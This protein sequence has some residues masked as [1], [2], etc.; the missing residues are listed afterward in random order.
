MNIMMWVG[1]SGMFANQRKLD[2][3]ANNLANVN[4][5]GFKA[6]RALFSDLLYNPSPANPNVQYGAGA[7]VGAAIRDATQGPIQE[8]NGEYDLAIYGPGYFRLAS[9]EGERVYS[10]AGTFQRDARG[11]L[12]DGNG[13]RLLLANNRPLQIP[14][15]AVSFHVAEDGEVTVEE[16]NRRGE[17][18]TRRLGRIG[19][20]QFDNVYGLEAIGGNMYR[21]T[22]ASGSARIRND[23]SLLR[24]GALEAANVDIATQMMDLILAQRAY[25]LSARAVQTAEQMMTMA[26]NLRG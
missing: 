1:A 24:Q 5:N 13:H 17:R 7:R 20:A 10:R 22:P 4:T 19:L 18:E 3:V 8:T 25:S 11:Y 15:D 26:N 23:G 2:I 6:S 9:P 12:T 16:I 21:E 14:D